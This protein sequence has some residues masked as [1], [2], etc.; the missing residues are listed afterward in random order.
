MILF[1]FL[2]FLVLFAGV[3]MLAAKRRRG[4]AFDYLLASRSISPGMAALS[5]IATNSSGFMFIGQVGFAYE[6]GLQALTLSLGWKLGDFLGVAYVHRAARREMERLG[7]IS[8][9]ELLARWGGGPERRRLRVV[10][11]LICLVFLSV[12]AAAQITAGGKAL[13]AL[14]GWDFSTG[15]VVGGA[16]VI[17]YCWAGGVRASV[18]TD[19]VQ[20]VVMALAMAMMLGAALWEIGGVSQM[21]QALSALGGGYLSFTPSDHA[22]GPWIGPGLFV[23][24]WVMGGLG[25]VGQPH[26]AL[27][28]FMLERVEQMPRMLWY[29]YMWSLLYT[30]LTLSAAYAARVLTPETLGVDP[31]LALPLLAAE[32]LPSFW[33][34]F[35]LAGVFAAAMSTADSQIVTCAAALTNDLGFRIW[36]GEQDAKAATLI[37]AAIIFAIAFMGHSSVFHLILAAWSAL[38]AAFAP[39]MLVFA[40]GARPSEMVSLAMCLTGLGV[41]AAWRSSGAVELTFDCLPAILAGL[42]VYAVSVMWRMAESM[43]QARGFRRRNRMID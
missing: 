30:A 10:A 25:A 34:G 11:A 43:M 16:I 40:F 38:A 17:L 37:L 29:Y 20:G 41:V 15:A 22:Y 6:F 33:V 39:L 3:G 4:G 26:I 23:F 21:I 31:E 32:L 18:W 9:S 36:G 5:A 24:G 1:S 12:Y 8:V 27:R 42:A 2:G 19:A 14:L 7:A 13:Q 28:F 35:L